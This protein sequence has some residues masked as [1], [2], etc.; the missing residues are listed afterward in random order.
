M[1]DSYYFLGRGDYARAIKSAEREIATRHDNYNESF[2]LGSPIALGKALLC[3]GRYDE[4][5]EH[6]TKLSKTSMYRVTLHFIGAGVARWFDRKKDDAFKVWTRGLKAGYGVFKG[7][8]IRL[9][10]YYAAVSARREDELKKAEEE[11]HKRQTRYK[12]YTGVIGQI[13][14]FLLGEISESDLYETPSEDSSDG[15]LT[16][17]ELQYIDFYVGVAALRQANR[18][19]F[20]RQMRKVSESGD[21]EDQPFEW[22]IAKKELR[23]I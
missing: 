5:Y 6:F 8:D 13:C 20:L 23:E 12:P 21:P 18:R 10:L 9:I 7:L 11:M 15:I 14:E 4:A 19:K 17:D 3:L 2:E 22:V 16:R 1:K